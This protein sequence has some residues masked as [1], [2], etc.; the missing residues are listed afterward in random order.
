[1]AIFSSS[2]DGDI[3]HFLWVCLMNNV[4]WLCVG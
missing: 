2:H 3:I 4:E 1:M